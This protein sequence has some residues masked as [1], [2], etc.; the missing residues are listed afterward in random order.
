MKLRL[1]DIKRQELIDKITHGLFSD[2][3]SVFLDG[4]CEIAFTLNKQELVKVDSNDVEVFD[5]YNPDFW[6]AYPETTPPDGVLMR[7]E[8]ENGLRTCLIYKDGKWRYETGELFERYE[9][10]FKVRRYRPWN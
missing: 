5:E 9:W 7:V 8:C 3:L 10:R 2:A 1:K 4:D 6:N